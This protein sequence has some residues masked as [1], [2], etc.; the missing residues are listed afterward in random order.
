M[1][2]N[3]IPGSFEENLIRHK[4]RR[5]TDKLREVEEAHRILNQVPGMPEW[6]PERGTI[7]K[8]LLAYFASQGIVID[9]DSEDLKTIDV[10]VE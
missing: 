5:A 2:K 7:G 8:R 10:E 4:T 3:Q 6:T 1:V 9:K